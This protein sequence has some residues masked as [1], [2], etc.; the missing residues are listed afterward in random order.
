MATL[1]GFNVPLNAGGAAVASVGTTKPNAVLVSCLVLNIALHQF[2]INEFS[3]QC[4]AFS[5]GVRPFLRSVI[6]YLL[7]S[8]SCVIFVLVSFVLEPNPTGLEVSFES[9]TFNLLIVLGWVV[10]NEE[11]RQTALEGFLVVRDCLFY[12]GTIG[13]LAYASSLPSIP[14]WWWIVLFA[15]FLF[16][17]ILNC[18]NSFLQYRTM[19][20]LNLLEDERVVSPELLL[21]QQPVKIDVNELEDIITDNQLQISE[22]IHKFGKLLERAVPN[23]RERKLHANFASIVLAFKT[24]IE[25]KRGAE[26]KERAAIYNRF[27]VPKEEE[28]FGS[29]WVAEEAVK[30]Q[31]DEEQQ[32]L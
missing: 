31:E 15:V 32:V 13:I 27:W 26:M 10:Y 19:K 6:Y 29:G 22:E 30:Q 16:Y 28:Y 5:K 2:C 25:I 17:W 20:L 8:L 7:T 1:A 24:A 18:F 11:S 14:V 23:E 12:G 4:Y 21:T 3:E 9:D